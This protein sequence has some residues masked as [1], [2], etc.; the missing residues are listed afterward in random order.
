MPQFMQ[1][2]AWSWISS[3]P[4][5]GYTSFQSSSRIGIGRDFGVWR[6][7]FKKPLGSGTGGSQGSIR[8]SPWDYAGPMQR[9]TALYTDPHPYWEEPGGNAVTMLAGGRP[10]S[11]GKRNHRIAPQP[12]YR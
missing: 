2:A 5:R 11:G 4:A 3:S 7:N 6:G 12:R 1:R 8:V 9:V 10:D